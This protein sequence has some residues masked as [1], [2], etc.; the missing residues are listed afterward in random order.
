MTIAQESKKKAGAKSED[1]TLAELRKSVTEISK[2]LATIVE[3]RGRAARQSAEAG[4]AMLRKN[5][6]QQPML[7]MGVAMLTGA[8]LALALVPRVGGRRPS[9]RWRYDAW[10]P[11][12]TRADLQELVDNLR[13]SVV[14]AAHSAP[15][16]SSLE[17]VAD[18]LSK[19]E[20]GSSL[21]SV[22]DKIS[23]WLQR[24]PEG[25]KPSK[26]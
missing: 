25:V 16:T 21:N 19:V 18:A 1:A 14:R 7:A 12:V 11:H 26:K 13:H 3:R 2:E 15:V 10:M 20:P 24:V 6:R 8:L 23:S 9:S 5:I 17:R 4:T 22:V